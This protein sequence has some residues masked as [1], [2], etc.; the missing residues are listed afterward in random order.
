M[1]L[2]LASSLKYLES[3]LKTSQ[4]VFLPEDVCEALIAKRLKEGECDDSFLSFFANPMTSRMVHVNLHGAPITDE[5]LGFIASHPIREL[6]VAEC[7]Q[8]TN[9]GIR[10]LTRCKNSLFSLNLGKCNQIT[11]F[12]DVGAFS[13]LRVLDVSNTAFDQTSFEA[14]APSLSHLQFL[15]MT[16]TE[17]RDLIPVQQLTSLVSLD[18]SLCGGLTSI[19]PLQTVKGTL[20]RLI[21]YNIV[22]L[23]DFTEPIK[24]ISTLTMLE[25]L[26]M[27]RNRRDMEVDTEAP[28][29]DG[30]MFKELSTLPH[31]RSLELSGTASVN[32]ADLDTFRPPH[33]RLEFLGLCMTESCYYPNLP[34]DEVTGDAGEAQL[35]ASLKRY[36][37]RSK[38]LISTLRELFGIIR[39]PAN[40]DQQ[41]EICM[42][43]TQAMENFQ[44][45]HRIQIA[46]SATLYH[47]SREEDE[48]ARV[49][50]AE[51]RRYIVKVTLDAME[52]HTAEEQ[53]Q[54][55]CCLTLCN[56]RIPD[57]VEHEYERVALALLKAAKRHKVDFIQRIA[58]GLCNLL[59]C[60]V[61]DD[62]KAFV[63]RDLQ[64]VETF[65][66]I[67]RYKLDSQPNAGGVLECC[68]SALW[69]VT[70]ETPYNCSLFI[71]LGGMELFMECKSNMPVSGHRELLRNM[72][73]LMGNVAEVEFLRPHLM[74][75]V[76]EFY[77]LMDN[78]NYEL[79]VSYNAAGI[80]CHLAS[81]GAQAWTNSTLDRD[82]AM[83]NL[84][85]TVE[86]WNIEAT[87]QMSYR[88]FQPI[89]RLLP[90]F[91][92]PAIQHWGAWALANLCGVDAAKYCILVRDEKGIPLL[93]DLAK[94]PATLPRTKELAQITLD[95]CYDQFGPSDEV[96][97]EAGD[98][99]ASLV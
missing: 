7:S 77:N 35:L 17:I 21:L 88:S 78:N 66:D 33:H 55:N 39:G 64:G 44:E 61:T 96:V 73:G 53:L 27:S 97:V 12:S 23:E 65:L 11:E 8:L 48:N 13:K 16:A 29:I 83:R 37:T 30:P 19:E 76:E 51:Q 67:I 94:H 87:R 26:D 5:G 93:E 75:Y 1:E 22:G 62:Q 54:K 41:G 71:E 10:H 46:G 43:V 72:L 52:N 63:G 92:T 58:I 36:Q 49:L 99:T 89:L 45:D 70:D 60:Q 68:W 18:L 82:E 20:R 56:F 50:T 47:L 81:D 95:R 25:H 74:L 98:S 42:L 69:N 31:L 80:L 34:A 38:Y 84:V 40:H 85:Q 57:E 6:N 24:T 15:N 86:E 14:S 79:E 32:M 28:F 59:V 3:S 90:R 9:E 4:N 91:D 2:C